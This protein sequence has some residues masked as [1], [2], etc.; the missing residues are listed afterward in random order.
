MRGGG[1][2]AWVLCK[3]DRDPQRSPAVVGDGV[4]VRLGRQQPGHL[5][6]VPAGDRGGERR[7]A[8][9]G[10]EPGPPR[11]SSS[12]K[13]VLP[14]CSKEYQVWKINDVMKHNNPTHESIHSPRKL[15]LGKL[16]S[17][18]HPDNFIL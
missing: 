8:V 1:G 3:P 10:G 12:N 13:I 18:K 4:G 17:T 2:Q 15:Q 14:H 11:V 16:A 9:D 5:Y 7:V 6:C